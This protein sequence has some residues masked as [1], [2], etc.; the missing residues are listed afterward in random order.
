M[1]PQFIPRRENRFDYTKPVDGSDPATDWHG[2]F[3]LDEEP[4]VLNPATGFVF[5]TNDWPYHAAGAS[6]PRQQDFPRYMDTAG[7][8]ARGVHAFQL[9]DGKRG[10]TLE[11]LLSSA[12]DSRLPFFESLIPSLFA[13]YDAAPD[14]KLA[15]QIAS[16]HNWDE[17]WSGAS[18]P[19]TLAVFWAEA[20]TRVS[21][22]P[23]LEALLATAPAQKLGALSSA[24]A[25]LDADFGTWQTPW[26][27]IN[28]F[29]RLSDDIQTHYDDSAPSIPVPFVAGTWGS[30][31]SFAAASGPNT[32]KRYG[33]SGNSFVAVVE[34][35]DR[36]RAVAVTAGGESG[37]VQSPHFNDQA[38]RYATGNLRPVCFYPDELAGHIERTYRP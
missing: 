9:L 22:S 5:N 12:F 10:F 3:P 27:E 24:V 26:G 21:G 38:T 16:L 4:H 6:S 17:H 14:P 32:K 37:D 33:S 18:V 7:E 34:F 23:R 11:S 15:E 25:K 8:N 20:L 30:L 31:A 35:G 2:I 36:V 13:A 19:T 1:H 29:Q 28:R